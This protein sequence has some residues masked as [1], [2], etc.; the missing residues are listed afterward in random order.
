MR[1]PL[2]GI[3]CCSAIPHYLAG[4]HKVPAEAP[5]LALALGHEFFVRGLRR[6]PGRLSQKGKKEET[7]KN[8]TSLGP[9]V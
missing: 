3:C 6:L 4:L 2:S 1:E 8:E 9:A 7:G 5:T